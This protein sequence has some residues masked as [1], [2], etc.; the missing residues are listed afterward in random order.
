MEIL[1]LKFHELD[2]PLVKLFDLF[3]VDSIPICK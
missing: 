3:T 1:F 2:L